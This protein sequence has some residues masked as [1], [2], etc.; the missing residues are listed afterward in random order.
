MSSSPAGP[1]LAEPIADLQHVPDQL[2][3]AGRPPQRDQELEALHETSLALMQRLDLADV[4]TAI[5]TRAAHLVGTRHGFLYLVNQEERVL[6]TKLGIGIHAGYDGYRLGYGEGLAGRVWQTGLPLLVNDYA[7]WSGRA[8]N[9]R[10]P[11]FHAVVAV[12]LRVEQ[13]VVGV[14][15]LSFDAPGYLPNAETVDLLT[16]FAQLAAIALDN[17]RLHT[18]ARQELAERRETEAALRESERQLR[19]LYATAQRQAQELE[20]LGQVRSALARELDLPT[21]FRTVVQAIVSTFGYT[22]VS[23]Y[24]LEG[25][26][27]VLQDQIGYDS[28]ITHIPIS[29]GVSGQVVRTR[30]PVLIEDV[31][32]HPSFLG[33]ITGIASEVC[34]PLLDQ[35]R[36]LGILNVESTGVALGAADLKLMI[37]LAEHIV[38]AIGRAQLYGAEQRR[39][40]QLEALRATMTEISANLDLDTLLAAILERE[41]ALLGATIGQVTLYDPVRG[42]LVAVKGHNLDSRYEGTR[43]ALGEGLAGHV[44]LT[45][46]PLVVPNYRTWDRRVATYDSVGP[47]TV[48]AVPMIAGDDLIGVL[49]VGDSN[50]A[51][52]FTDDDVELLSLFAQQATIAIQNARLFA[53]ASYLAITDALTGLANRRHFFT[54]AQQEIDRTLRYQRPLAVLMLDVDNFKLINDGYG[55]AAGDRVLQEI[56][57]LCR[58]TL[59]SADVVGRYGGEEIAVLLPETHE[60]AAEEAAGR[61]R[62]SIE[63]LQLDGAKLHVTV[64]IGVAGATGAEPVALEHLIERADHALYIA[65]R[66]GKNRVVVDRRG[67]RSSPAS[68]R[69]RSSIKLR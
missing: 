18:A 35:Q 4:L 23:I 61:L 56:G 36:V 58:R 44:A 12:P 2:T 21:L 16:R 27:L 38:I 6:E 25:D 67:W 59:R 7:A 39:V 52:R 53:E 11:D 43:V 26:T 63:E 40:R 3:P 10:S 5:L 24:L 8:A 15:G 22:L 62:A 34:V 28:V 57:A 55:H 48:L 42:D 33:A 1:L 65:K 13:E 68:R 19:A 69:S 32:S 50:M 54:L 47:I 60:E 49:V 17:A 9:I 20:L 37:A 14:I 29:S 30:E 66:T 45:R 46:A 51:R 64:S 31:R 41:V